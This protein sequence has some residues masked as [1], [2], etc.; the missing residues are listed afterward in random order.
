MQRTRSTAHDLPRLI[1]P[2]LI[3]PRLI[4]PRTRSDPWKDAMCDEEVA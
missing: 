2:R 4:I 3:F 1:F